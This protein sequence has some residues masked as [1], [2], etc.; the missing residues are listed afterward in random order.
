MTRQ[1]MNLKETVYSARHSLRHKLA[2]YMVLLTVLLIGMF[3]AGLFLSGS[4]TSPKAETAKALSTQ[5]EFF[6]NDMRSQWR[7]VSVM[8]VNLSEELTA[9]LEGQLA[10]SR[11][12]F[13]QLNEN[14]GAIREVEDALLDPLCYYVR[15]ADCSGAFVVLQVRMTPDG[16]PDQR[17]GLYVQKNNAEKLTNELLLYRGLA[18][19]GKAH[20]VMPHRKW[21]RE[22]SVDT[23]PTYA[24][25]IASA[26]LPLSASCRSSDLTPLPGTS[27]RAMFLTVP[28]I[29]ADG[30]V[31]G[32]CGFSINQTYYSGRHS[33]PSG[34]RSLACMMTS[35]SSQGLDAG[36]GLMTYTDGGFF[37]VVETVLT[38]KDMG[39]GLSVFSGGGFSYIGV[40]EPFTAAAGDS[41]PHTLAVLIPR[42][43]YVHAALIRL[44][45]ILLLVVLLAAFV[46]VCCLYASRR[47]LSPVQEDITQLHL[48]GR[49]KGQLNFEEFESLSGALHTEDT[50]HRALVS[51]LES[52]R[53][54]AQQQARQL[55]DRNQT[56]SEQLATTQEHLTEVESDAKMLAE[57]QKDEM[58][59]EFYQFFLDKA[60][61]LK[62][63]A[64]QLFILYAQGYSIEQAGEY[65]GLKRNNVKYH[66]KT[67][68]DTLGIGR[69]DQIGKYCA[70]IRQLQ[71]KHLLPGSE[72][73]PLDENQK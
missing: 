52:A 28:L 44:L 27:E 47:Y 6:R 70:V 62:G 35:G 32:L 56:L 19:V 1:K 20:G 69:I 12:A 50:A 73:L 8:G 31:Y 68:R 18:S 10:D 25:R 14:I 57:S 46:V 42:E 67:L 66:N 37:P 29:G 39:D 23:F 13:G 54:E 63:N 21:A 5:M 3:C 36:L 22:F 34:L 59:P 30:T 43:E 60:A 15:Q 41:R 65:L 17:A 51:T 24:E 71:E 48:P 16:A 9:R 33:Q 53:A 45:Q 26:A 55:L 61:T 11:L 40:T 7:N 64:R 4:F 58:D 72:G 2:G 38:G 49:G